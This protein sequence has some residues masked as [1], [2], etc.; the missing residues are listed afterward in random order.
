METTLLNPYSCGSMSVTKLAESIRS[1]K[2]RDGI[3]FMP[4]VAA[5]YPDLPTSVRLIQSFQK[6]GAAALEIGFPF[7]DPIADGP[8]IQEAFTV[9][10][11][12]KLKIDEIFTSLKDV[13]STLTVPMV[14]MVSYSIVFRYGLESFVAKAKEAGFSGLLLPDLPPPEAEEVCSKVQQSGLDTVLLVAPSTPADR[15]E[16]IVSLCSGFVYC[17]S[18]T[19]I[20]GARD[21][22]PPELEENVRKIKEI[23]KVP[24]CVGFGVSKSEHLKQ[25]SR[26]ADGAIVASAIIKRMQQAQGDPIPA[27][28]AYCREILA[29]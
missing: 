16:K 8:T 29:K 9:A 5:G 7:S 17:L 27:A 23:S 2:S 12:K 13:K 18:V 25:L 22:L 19:G 28:E 10:L 24:V 26:S 20:T 21:S 15:R 11:S 6:I 14:A 1:A 3:A 4:F